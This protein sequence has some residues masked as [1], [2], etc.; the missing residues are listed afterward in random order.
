MIGNIDIS[1]TTDV[2]R[3]ITYIGPKVKNKAMENSIPNFGC[4]LDV[5]FSTVPPD[6]ANAIIANK[7]RPTPVI[8]KP[9]IAIHVF[10]PAS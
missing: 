6:M 2:V 1:Y 3:G 7:T 5:S 10:V 8:K 9:D 4:T